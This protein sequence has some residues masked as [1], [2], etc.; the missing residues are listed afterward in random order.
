VEYYEKKINNNS[1]WRNMA[2]KLVVLFDGTWNTIKDHTNVVRLAE[3][4]AATSDDG[5]EQLPPFYDKGIGTHALDRWTGGIFGYGL[6]E[7]IRDGYRWLAANY[8][9]GDEIFIFGFSRGAYTARSLAGLIRKCG[10][11]RPPG[12]A[13]VR[14]TQEQFFRR[15][16][17]GNLVQRAYDLYRDKK[18]HPDSPEANAFRASVA[19]EARIKFIGV[20]DTVG[21]LG[22]PLTGVP[23]GRDY[24]QWHD[25]ELSKIVDYAY[26]A[27]AIDEH[28][29]DFSATVWTARK[30]QNIEV[31]QRWFCGAHSNIGGGY[32]RDPL[33]KLALAWLMQKAGACGLAY[34]STIAITAEERLAPISDSYGEFMFG[35]YKLFKAGKRHYRPF[36]QGV[37]ETIDDSVWQRWDARPD[38][39]PP[40]VAAQ[41]R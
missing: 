6:S 24:F 12:T 32:R 29:E 38:Y 28:R 27:L 37:N 34:K 22:I 40:T 2:R 30:P 10:I 26:H 9:P 33:P 31:E 4:I 11:L 17:N 1:G 5:S 39:R 23:F 19:Q 8:R 15:S 25:T 16:A 20:W 35:L 14:N 36:G 21:S 41:R 18:I 3:L 13:E 7:N